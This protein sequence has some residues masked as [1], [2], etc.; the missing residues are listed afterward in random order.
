MLISHS[1]LSDLGFPHRHDTPKLGLRINIPQ[2]TNSPSYSMWTY[3]LT[4]SKENIPAFLSWLDSLCLVQLPTP[5]P[6][7]DESELTGAVGCK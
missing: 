5:R 2:V 3:K 1:P 6:S 7:T 4:P